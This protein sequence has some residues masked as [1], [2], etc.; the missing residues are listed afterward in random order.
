MTPASLVQPDGVQLAAYFPATETLLLRLDPAVS[1]STDGELRLRLADQR[2]AFTDFAVA[3][4]E[5]H[6]IGEERIDHD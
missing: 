5:Q 6:L 3:W 4:M 1:V 2:G